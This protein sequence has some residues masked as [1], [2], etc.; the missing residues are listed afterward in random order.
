MKTV[1]TH[2]LFLA[3]GLL[4]LFASVAQA[5][6]PDVREIRPVVM[7][8]VDTSGSM[9]YEPG[10][11]NGPTGTFPTCSMGTTTERSR[12]L[13][14]LEALTGPFTGTP[15]FNCTTDRRATFPG[16]PD[17]LYPM[18][19]T[20]LANPALFP[21]GLGILD[22]YQ[23]RVKF[24][25]MTFDNVYGL[26]GNTGG[27]GNT[28]FIMVPQAEWNGMAGAASP[29]APGSHESCLVRGDYS[30]G[31]SR[32]FTFP[33]C[34]TTYWVNGGSRRM[35]AGAD[36]FGGSLVSV[37]SDTPANQ[38]LLNNAQ[39]QNSLLTMRP[40][41]G[42]PTGALLQDFEW[43]VQNNSDVAL[44]DP[45][46][47][48]RPKYVVLITDGQ[49]ND[50]FRDS[51]C[52]LPGNVCPYDRPEDTA[53]RLCAYNGTACT[54]D[55]A[56]LYVL[57]FDVNDA[58]ASASL[59][60]I[61]V[62]GGTTA[63]VSVN[64][65]NQ[66][67]DALRVA[68]DRVATTTTT[69]TAPIFM[70]SSA[71]AGDT[72][73]LQQSYQFTSGFRSVGYQAVGGVDRPVQWTGVLERT[74][75]L[76][77]TDLVPMNQPVD[78]TDRFQDILNS[79]T[80]TRR[81]ITVLPSTVSSDTNTAQ[82]HLRGRV[83]NAQS[84]SQLTDALFTGGSPP[85]VAESYTSCATPQTSNGIGCST[86][87][88]TLTTIP[89][90][91]TFAPSGTD[92]QVLNISGSRTI[93]GTA[94]DEAARR[95]RVQ[96]WLHATS[97]STRPTARLG[98]IFH[99]NP[100]VMTAPRTERAD[101][102]YNTFRTAV[103]N[104]ANVMFVGTNDGLL[105]AFLTEPR[106]ISSVLEPA[107][108]ELW[109]MVPPYLLGSL[110]DASVARRM[111]VDGT[112]VV[113]D[114]YF[115]RSPG[116][117]TATYRSVLLVGLRGGGNAYMALDVTDPLDPQFLWQF[118][119]PYLGEAVGTPTI[120]QVFVTVNGISQ[121]RAVAILPGGQGHYS[122]TASAAGTTGCT[123]TGDI[124]PASAFRNG[125]LITSRTHRQCWSQL[126]N[127]LQGRSL[128]VVDMQTG[129]QLAGFGPRINGTQEGDR[130]PIGSPITGSV[131]AFLNEVG[132]P[133]NLAYVT[134]ADGVVWRLNMAHPS[135]AEWR[136]QPLFDT[137]FRVGGAQGQP[138][139]DAPV[140]SVDQQGRP[141]I[142][143]G[144]GN[145]DNLE[146]TATNFVFSISDETP[147]G[148]TLPGGLVARANWEIRLPGEQVTG[149]MQLFDSRLYFG[150]FKPVSGSNACDFGTSRLW[151]VHYYNASGVQ[152]AAT[153]Y[154]DV[155]MA[156]AMGM[157]SVDGGAI[158]TRFYDVGPNQI[159]MG[160]AITQKPT[161]VSGANVSDPYIGTRYRISA[162]G[163]G[164]FQLVAQVSGRTSAGGL[165]SVGLATR[166]LPV[167]AFTS[168]VVSWV[169]AADY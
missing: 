11:S 23:E 49:P 115:S 136:F 107:G 41:G 73:A 105:H 83:L 101:S 91:G 140:L 124:P 35:L 132:Q 44:G 163:S 64:Q 122:A 45:Y 10:S 104:R 1:Q 67:I 39:I 123:A 9:E 94:L 27:A 72:S 14:L 135:P 20:Y 117:A 165:S 56:G 111:M 164:Q 152:I 24:G 4:G 52:E 154:P 8:L 74:R 97:T 82:T 121:Q 53:A 26:T 57:A 42:T 93:N 133:V 131:S 88:T 18:P 162:T 43:Y 89:T 22:V 65:F 3:L 51:G 50:P 158:D 99:S 7:M 137:G 86:A 31:P 69:R 119:N 160:T 147:I 95:L 37:G 47:T 125:T 77:G 142:L 116:A 103:A 81:L 98:D 156:P 130:Y 127:E 85:V 118:T 109:G 59:N 96:N 66:L 15:N 153:G 30:Y 108:H 36:S 146:S 157:S 70:A 58:A 76:C 28:W 33:G 113:R 62:N 19:S 61:A 13:T 38:F 79:R 110:E 2:C 141:V 129:R 169:S 150:T 155:E 128:F 145:M 46:R 21:Q 48:C 17:E 120:A 166:N 25:L 161:C 6:D 54:G 87:A 92:N 71:Y 16:Q 84:N 106:T 149:S 144:T 32:P 75:F 78:A 143:I 151:G 68:L 80:A 63:A 134:D 102:A 60:Q 90:T 100:V 55:I 148:T 12:W 159:V 29:C 138:A 168:R 34:T 126:S 40:S 5:Q 139:A 114:V 167:P 112:P